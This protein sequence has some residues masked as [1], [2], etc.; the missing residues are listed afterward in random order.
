MRHYSHLGPVAQPHGKPL[1]RE[2]IRALYDANQLL[3]W[4]AIARYCHV[5]RSTIYRAMC[6]GDLHA[7]TRTEVER[8][9]SAW[10]TAD[11]EKRATMMRRWSPARRAAQQRK[12]TAA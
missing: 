8:F 6:G 3:S 10:H 12:A 4:A 5:G 9:V 7:S 11:I 2:T 1:A